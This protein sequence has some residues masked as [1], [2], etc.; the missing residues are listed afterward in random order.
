[1]YGGSIYTIHCLHKEAFV[2]TEPWSPRVIERLTTN[3]LGKLVF[4]PTI[5]HSNGFDHLTFLMK[6]YSTFIIR[7]AEL[8]KIGPK[9]LTIRPH[10]KKGPNCKKSG[11]RIDF[12]QGAEKTWGRKDLEPFGRGNPANIQLLGTSFQKARRA[13][14]GEA[15]PGF[16]VHWCVYL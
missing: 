8:L 14:W 6:G 2:S 4:L 7:W 1:M 10:R 3:K 15:R 9:C 12:F 13:F 5:E 16:G 11:G